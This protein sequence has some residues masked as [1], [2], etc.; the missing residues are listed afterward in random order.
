MKNALAL[1]VFPYFLL[2]VSWMCWAQ[3]EAQKPKPGPEYQRL[4]YFVGDWQT[5]GEQ[6]PG[7][8]GPSGKFSGTDHN[9]M[10]GDFFVIFHRD[11]RDPTGSGKEIGIM[12]YDPQRK[13]YTY[14]H[15]GDDGDIGRGTATISGDTWVVL[16]P[17][18][19]A[20]QQGENKFKGRMTIKEVSP[21]SYTLINE[22]S[23]DGGP[24]TK[25]QEG[26]ATK[27]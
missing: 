9:E 8:T 22:I 12:G 16:W 24:W 17:A 27:K 13:V 11:E 14:E 21:T 1:T 5:E 26:K 20:C 18:I 19:D 4:H 25:F 2:T 7:P 15:F 10:L 3:A 6:K 23:I